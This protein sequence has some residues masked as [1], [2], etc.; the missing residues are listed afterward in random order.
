M[1]IEDENQDVFSKEEETSEEETVEESTEEKEDEETTEETKGEEEEETPASEDDK[2]N[3]S[4]KLIPESRLKA[5]LTDQES[6]LRRELTQTPIQAPDRN[7]HPEE[8][9]N[10]MRMEFSREAMR[11]AHPDYEEKI[12]HYIEMEKS[13]PCTW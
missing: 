2:E 7:T 6:R 1:P 10:H 5:A 13:K 12:L 3:K 4:E 11:D 9:E 8:Y